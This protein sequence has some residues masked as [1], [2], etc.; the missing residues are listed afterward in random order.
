MRLLY[1]FNI[2]QNENI[3]SLCK[4]SNNLC[5]QALYIFRETL[6]NEDKWLSYFELDT[7][8]KNTKN[9][10]G[11]INYKLL[12]AQCSQQVLR[13]LD[14][15]IKGYYK[16]VQDYKKHPNK[17][18]GKPGLPSY[19]KRGSEFNMYYTNQ[20]CKIKDGK[21]VLS[22]ELSIDIPQY[23]K[24]SDLI[25]NF[26]HVRIKPLACGYKIEIIYEV[27]DAEVSKGREEKI[28]SIDLGIDNLAT[29][30]SEDFTIIFSGKFV[31]SHNQLFNK[32]LAKLNSI[33]DLQKI[34]GTTRRIKKLYYDREQYME[35]VFHKISR[36]I[37]N[38]LID[39]KI[40]KLIVGYN[41]G[42]KQNVNMGKKN[43]QKFTQIPFARLVS[44]LEYKCELVGI[45]IV[46]HEESYTS[47]CDSLAFEKIGKH[48]NYLG[49]RRKRGLFQSSVGKL[50]NA[51]VNGALNI[52]RKVVG[53]S[54][55]SIRRII[56][57]GLLF[58]PVRI[59][60]VFC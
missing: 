7:I 42:W 46:I 11:N 57:R 49:R 23:E 28:A 60:N 36:K 17:Y 41:K 10:D 37:V 25:K 6:S 50:I 59:T 34:K 1:K 48:E 27:K 44:Y 24:Y 3:S 20:N 5:N 14:K 29:I 52:M 15:N 58:N 39:S 35:D 54:C 56:D 51:D 31:K 26:K 47:K 8:M 4:I 45:E 2:G 33:K 53:D 21:I 19:R 43:N 13:I 22:K 18:K 16:S 30:V 12:K 40:T 55:E 32:T 9:L 38:L